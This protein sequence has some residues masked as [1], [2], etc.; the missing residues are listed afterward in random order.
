MEIQCDSLDGLLYRLYSAIKR[1]GR[2]HGSGTRGK[3]QE[4]LGVSLRILKSRARISRSENR[5]K[6]FSALGEL[7]WYLSGSDRLDFIEAYVSEYRRDAVDGTLEGAVQGCY[8][9]P[10]AA[11]PRR[12]LSTG[13]HHCTASSAGRALENR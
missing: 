5:G 6:P 3:S 2:P 7:L 12:L 8:A 4:L 11:L 9:Q 10:V 13:R 1:D